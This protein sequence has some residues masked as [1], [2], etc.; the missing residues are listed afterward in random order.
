MGT[1][2]PA[3]TPKEEGHMKNFNIAREKIKAATGADFAE[4]A[5]IISYMLTSLDYL[6]SHNKNYNKKQFWRIEELHD[7]VNCLFDAEI[8]GK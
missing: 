3:T 2:N 6:A 1:L 7:I 5:D 4:E 8:Y